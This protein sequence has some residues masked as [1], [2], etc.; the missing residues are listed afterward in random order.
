MS[1][2]YTQISAFLRPDQ[3]EALDKLARS[4]GIHSR[5]PLLRWAVDAFLLSES[6]TY[7]IN[8][9]IEDPAADVVTN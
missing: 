9:H 1:D 8:E 3:I 6:S 7:R 4:K 2:Q 5:Q